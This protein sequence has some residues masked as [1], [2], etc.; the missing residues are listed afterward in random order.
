MGSDWTS[1]GTARSTRRSRPA[2]V[3]SFEVK[4][5]E[6]PDA[7]L[8]FALEPASVVLV[9]SSKLCALELSDATVAPRH[10]SLEMTGTE[11]RLVDLSPAK[12]TRVNGVCAHEAYLVGGE[13][14]RVGATVIAVRRRTYAEAAP[15]QPT[16]FGR[17]VGESMP[18]RALYIVLTT[19]AQKRTPLV[20]HGERGTGKRLL[21]EELHA[22]GPWK[23]GPF[24]VVPRHAPIEAFFDPAKGGTLY[25]EECTALQVRELE[26]P[27][28]V[29]VIFGARAAFDGAF[30]SVT[31]PPLR[32]RDGDVSLLA[33]H[34]W[35]ELGAEGSLP[36][37]FVARHEEHPWPGNVRELRIAVQDRLHHG[38]D[39]GAVDVVPGQRPSAPPPDVLADV[40]ES[41][42]SFVRAR[43]R[44]LAEFERRYVDRALER[45]GH[46]VARAAANSGIA[47]R[48]FQV[49]KSRRKNA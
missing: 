46:N 29:R 47:H 43:H 10:C 34:F 11:V 5:I 49:L 12:E 31:L 16:S 18:M 48:Y 22:H 13:I 19:L 30:E 36:D 35:A 7:G 8:T 2:I 37:D 4:V 9:G 44:V 32:E 27:G 14:V 28:D 3:T 33:R 42:E 40:V 17:V 1:V 38:A 6:G 23:D 15:I 21:A 39:S 25:V 26:I 20:I 45:A 24:V 41:E